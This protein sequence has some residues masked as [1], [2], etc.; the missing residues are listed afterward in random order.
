MDG[1]IPGEELQEW[2][3]YFIVGSKPVY[4][5]IGYEVLYSVEAVFVRKRHH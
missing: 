5:V 1:P 4:V 3:F 2:I